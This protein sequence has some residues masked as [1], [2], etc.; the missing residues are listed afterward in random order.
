MEAIQL[1]QLWTAG[2]VLAGFQT[3]ALTWRIN[4]EVS[5]ES[6]D[7]TTWV[8]LT[9]AFVAASFLILVTGVFL[10]PLAGSTST[11]MAAKWLG[12]ALML[13]TASPF[14]L[15]GRYNLYCSWGKNGCRLRITKQE[16]LAC[17]VSTVLVAG[18][19]WWILG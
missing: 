12:I 8:T 16:W 11:Q 13:F 5:M 6:E 2:A 10:A 14:I 19:A 1:P 9:D 4:R 3:A 7:E 15:A 17:G 18:G